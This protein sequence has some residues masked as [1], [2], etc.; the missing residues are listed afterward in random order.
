MMN[1]KQILVALLLFVSSA[2][3]ADRVTGLFEAYVPVSSQSSQDQRD[4]INRALQQVLVK[5]SGTRDVLTHPLI[6][7]N[8]KNAQQLLQLFRFETQEQKLYLQAS[9]DSAKVEQVIRSAGFPIWGAVRPSSLIWL[10]E[11]QQS[12]RALISEDRVS[13]VKKQIQRV[14]QSRGLSVGFPLLDLTDLEQISWYDVW[15]RFI[16]NI[17]AA[18]QRYGAESILSARLYQENA[19]DPSA[20]S[21]I[22]SEAG[23]TSN[24]QP[25][26]GTQSGTHSRFRSGHQSNAN[27]SWVLDWNLVD[28]TGRE[29]GR[30]SGPD[31]LKLVE[32]LME[33]LADKQGERFAIQS[34]SLA[35]AE[36]LLLNV[37]NVGSLRDYV[38]LQRFFQNLTAVTS[39]SLSGLNGSVAQFSVQL[40]G[41]EQDLL[42]ALSLE[43]RIRRARD[44]FGQPTPELDFEWVP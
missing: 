30:L 10:A 28:S 20:D 12:R 8:L 1:V 37:I 41:T 3:V 23:P 14:A 34:R 15:G 11:E 18:S 44:P 43:T 38:Q 4:G 5:V 17:V 33:L 6:R 36:P 16:D 13:E 42:N 26:R 2:S 24:A 22:R 21:E 35:L 7:S 29:E 40:L 39:V 27:L 31:K 9:F 25:R 32:Q 19:S